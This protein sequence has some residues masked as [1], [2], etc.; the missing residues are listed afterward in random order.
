MS[1]TQYY[2]NRRQGRHRQ[3]VSRI[4]ILRSWG[5]LTIVAIATHTVQGCQSIQTR[6]PFQSRRQRP[7]M[8]GKR[9]QREGLCSLVRNVDERL[10]GRIMSYDE[11]STPCAPTNESYLDSTP[12]QAGKY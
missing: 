5:M 7:P 6:N 8:L 1:L 9:N 4:L 2:Q 10:T 3:S 12:K 11:R